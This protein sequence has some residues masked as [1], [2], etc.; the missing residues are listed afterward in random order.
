MATA[1]NSRHLIRKTAALIT[2]P[3]ISLYAGAQMLAAGKTMNAV[4]DIDLKWGILL[5]AAVV[6]GYCAKGGLRA[7]IITQCV[8][9]MIMLSTSIGA[10]ILVTVIAGG[11][12]KL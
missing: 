7:S 1:D 4:I 9:A 6:I 5:S 10:L 8:Q 3:M 12:M 11:R 2:F